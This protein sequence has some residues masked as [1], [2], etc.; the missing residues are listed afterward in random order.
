MANA[1]KF[2]PVR[3][4][5]A[6][7]EAAVQQALGM[8]GATSEEIQVEVLA[9]NEKGVTVRVMPR[10]EAAAAAPSPE[11][12]QAMPPEVPVAEV[13]SSEA[14]PTAMAQAETAPELDLADAAPVQNSLDQEDDVEAAAPAD[15][16]LEEQTESTLPV[17]AAPE[18]VAAPIDPAVQERARGVAQEFLERMGL[19]AQAQIA[20]PFSALDSSERVVPRVYLQIEGEDVGVLIGKHG[21][22]LQS[23]QY[24]LN[25]T[26]N[27]NVP[28]AAENGS[29]TAG[30]V[31]M[32]VMVDAGGYRVRRAA[33]LE[34]MAQEGATR[35]KRE[36]R[37]VRLEPMPAHERR[38]VHIALRED[39]EITSGSEGQEPMRRV[40]I[41]PAGMH[42]GSDDNR[43]RFSQERRGGGFGGGRSSGGYGGPGRGGPR[44]GSGGRGGRSDSR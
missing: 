2:S 33:A 32:H 1:K 17:A 5:A 23:F 44:G 13:P 12:A 16:D 21:Q 11:L 30:D 35:A 3:V 15:A 9:R 8:T 36:R 38:L 19:D 39:S 29:A 14:A 27:N 4:T 6:T 18:R 7:E 31:G 40:I 34:Q 22:T 42:I 43:S 10:S 26:L 20:A 24:L 41:A 25:L 28:P 37:L